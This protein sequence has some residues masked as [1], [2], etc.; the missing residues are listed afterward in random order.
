MLT[1]GVVTTE[2]GSLLQYFT[3]LNEKLTPPTPVEARTLEHL[4]GVPSKAASSG[5][6]EIKVRIHIQNTRKYLECGN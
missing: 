1:E 6:E 2:A 5:R 4:V 3:A